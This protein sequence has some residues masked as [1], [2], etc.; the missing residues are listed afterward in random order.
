MLSF[1]ESQ[2]AFGFGFPPLKF[3][4]HACISVSCSH[5]SSSRVY[6]IRIINPD[7][8]SKMFSVQ[9]GINLVGINLSF[10]TSRHLSS[11][12]WV[13]CK[14]YILQALPAFLVPNCL[15]YLSFLEGRRKSCILCSCWFPR[16]F[17]VPAVCISVFSL[18]TNRS[19]TP[20]RFFCICYIF[21]FLNSGETFLPLH[22]GDTNTRENASAMRLP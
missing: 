4:I 6:M 11:Y 7:K 16:A 19:A 12:L 21:F 20:R 9:K 10:W 1:T 2:R 8:R 17:E 14:N 22:C 15:S 3:R 18:S 13:V 5:C